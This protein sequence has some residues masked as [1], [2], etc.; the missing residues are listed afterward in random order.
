IILL[1]LGGFA[2]YYIHAYI[3]DGVTFIAI[4]SLTFLAKRCSLALSNTKR[5]QVDLATVDV[6]RIEDIPCRDEN[7]DVVCD[8]DGEP[9]IHTDGAGFIS[10]DLA[11]MCAKHFIE[12]NGSKDKSY[13][14][15]DLLKLEEESLGME[16]IS[17]PPLLVQFCIFK[18]G[19]AVKGTLLVNKKIPVDDN[20]YLIGT[21]EPTG[22]LESD[23]VCVIMYQARFWC[24]EIRVSILGIYTFSMHNMYQQ[25]KSLSEMPNM[26]FSSPPKGGDR[27]E[28][29]TRMVI[30]MA[31]YIILGI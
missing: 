2:W 3:E 30:L 28:V 13:E 15:V 31:I 16:G 19:Y 22:T 1:I 9:L 14:F 12:A 10:E 21:T 20:F 26:A 18:D 5:L 23:E 11:I 24:M 6:Q 7:G 4:S 27:W 25:W 17:D 8:K 29:K